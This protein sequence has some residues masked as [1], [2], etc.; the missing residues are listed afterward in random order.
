M[1]SLDLWEKIMKKMYFANDIYMK[2]QQ[3]FTLKNVN[4]YAKTV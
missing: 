2:P 4:F 1:Q 3:I